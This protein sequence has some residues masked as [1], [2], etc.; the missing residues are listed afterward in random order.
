[1][2]EI[3][4]ISVNDKLPNRPDE[5]Y[6]V[7]VRNKNKECGIPLMDIQNFTSDGVF[8]G[9]DPDVWEKVVYWSELPKAP[10]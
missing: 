9:G 5:D 6:L 7:V 3:N 1:M 2:E 8:V 10:F 4:W